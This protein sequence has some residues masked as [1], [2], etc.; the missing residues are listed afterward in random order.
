M[1]PRLR[2]LPDAAH[3]GQ[4]NKYLEQINFPSPLD[5][6][7]WPGPPSL[8]ECGESFPSDQIPTCGGSR[9]ETAV[10][11]IFDEKCWCDVDLECL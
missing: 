5:P 8:P 3:A 1:R 11:R 7:K 6:D 10:A 2:E 4:M 9:L